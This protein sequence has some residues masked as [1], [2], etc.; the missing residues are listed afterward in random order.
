MRKACHFDEGEIALVTPQAIS[1]N[2]EEI[3][4][5]FTSSV[6]YRSSL[7][8]RNDKIV[9]NGCEIFVTEISNLYRND[10]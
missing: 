4:V 7:L 3:L 1:S 6:R 5:R 8:R 2:F 10:K 9:E